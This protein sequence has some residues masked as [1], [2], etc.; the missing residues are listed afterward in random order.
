VAGCLELLGC[1]GG[2][3]CDFGRRMAVGWWDEGA[4]REGANVLWGGCLT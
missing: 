4:S 2:G 1:P 3:F